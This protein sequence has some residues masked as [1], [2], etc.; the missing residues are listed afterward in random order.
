VCGGRWN[1]VFEVPSGTDIFRRATWERLERRSWSLVFNWSVPLA[2]RYIVRSVGA[3]SINAHVIHTWNF[4]ALPT[5]ASKYFSQENIFRKSIEGNDDT[6]YVPHY[7]TVIPTIFEIINY[8]KPSG[9]FCA[10]LI[11][12]QTRKTMY[13]LHNI[14]AC[15][16]NHLCFRKEKILHILSVGL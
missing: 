6:F 15:S 14:E 7:C 1:R 3:G 2:C 5:Q 8:W 9:H 16:H 4:H 11:L 10:T 12:L 13:L